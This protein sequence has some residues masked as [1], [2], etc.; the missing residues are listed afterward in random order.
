MENNAYWNVLWEISALV[1]KLLWRLI[2]HLTWVL[3]ISTNAFSSLPPCDL[4]QLQCVFL[5]AVFLGNMALWYRSS[6]KS[7]PWPLYVIRFTVSKRR[8]GEKSMGTHTLPLFLS[9]SL[10]PLY[11]FSSLKNTRGLIHLF[12]VKMRK[13]KFLSPCMKQNQ[14][15]GSILIP[16]MVKTDVI[17][18]EGKRKQNGG[19]QGK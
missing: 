12:F 6:E 13:Y 1:K 5:L 4:K 9:F 15:S 2:W 19:W 16:L 14:R 10:S 17:V 18:G 11:P 7:S 8:R 3:G